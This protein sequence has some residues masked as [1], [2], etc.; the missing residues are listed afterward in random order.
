M[1]TKLNILL[2]IVLLSIIICVVIFFIHKNADKGSGTKTGDTC[3]P[4][5]TMLQNALYTYDNDGDCMFICKDGYTMYNDVCLG[6][7]DSCELS[8]TDFPHG[9]KG[10]MKHKQ[11]VPTVCKH[12][13]K[14][15]ESIE[16]LSESLV[17]NTIST[18]TE[19]ILYQ[20]DSNN[21]AYYKYD[22]N[23]SLN[24]V[25]E[26]KQFYYVYPNINLND[27]TQN[28]LKLKVK[29]TIKNTNLKLKIVFLS[30]S[31][32]PTTE[33]LKNSSSIYWQTENISTYDFDVN[34]ENLEFTIE[35]DITHTIFGIKSISLH[36]LSDKSVEYDFTFDLLFNDSISIHHSSIFSEVNINA[37]KTKCCEVKQYAKSYDDDCT[38]KECKETFNLVNGECKQPGTSCEPE[39][40]KHPNSIESVFN[41]LNECQPIECSDNYVLN[42]NKTK[43]CP[44]NDDVYI[45]DDNCNVSICKGVSIPSLDYKTCKPSN[46]HI[47]GET[48]TCGDKVHSNINYNYTSNVGA[49]QI[50]R[51]YCEDGTVHYL[52][53]EDITTRNGT[54][55]CGNQVIDEQYDTIEGFTCKDIYSNLG[56]RDA[57]KFPQIEKDGKKYKV[58]IDNTM[59]VESNHFFSPLINQMFLKDKVRNIIGSKYNDDYNGICIVS[60]KTYS[61]TITHDLQFTSPRKLC[62]DL[63]DLKMMIVY[64]PEIDPERQGGDYGKW[65]IRQS[66]KDK[67]FGKKI[68]NNIFDSLEEVVKYFQTNKTSLKLHT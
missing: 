9:E 27:Y 17:Y 29:S 61:K 6:E 1:V 22:S 60:D 40:S 51:S 14:S 68:G 52:M 54:K 7:D 45:Y 5:G 30:F 24:Y 2:S 55:Y 16:L 10:T 67:H 50:S 66:S 31:R 21:T 15:K 8:K 38:I 41:N 28:K 18:I 13:L 4:S 39:T 23:Y 33:H 46:F 64:L 36:N 25:T 26:D 48:V 43:C 65:T 58:D 34:N 32:N 53:D 3:I 59:Y 11:C 47:D 49:N 44:R 56:Y 62:T 57:R 42:F 20:K 35:K 12:Y 37:T 63:L 19:Q